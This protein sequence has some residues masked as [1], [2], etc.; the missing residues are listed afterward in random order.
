MVIL[1]R[2]NLE[3]G[4]SLL[5]Q[6]TGR[7]GLRLNEEKTRRLRLDIGNNVDFLGFRFHNVR[8]RQMAYG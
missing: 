6:Y 1:A 7:L 3:E 2:E 5:H 8:S 4:I